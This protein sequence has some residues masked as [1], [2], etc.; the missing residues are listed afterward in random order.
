MKQNPDLT[1]RIQGHTDN[2][3]TEKYNE[4]LGDR[5]AMAA[6]Q[7]LLNQGISED[8]ITTASSGYFMPAATNKTEW[9]RA[10]NRRDEFKWTR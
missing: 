4:K 7:Y 10:K 6:K 5:R 1:I 3:G 2:L 9:G 8:R